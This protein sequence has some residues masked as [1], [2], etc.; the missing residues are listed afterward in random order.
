MENMDAE[1]KYLMHPKME[2]FALHRDIP[3][4]N[5]KK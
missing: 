1:T 4:Q 3:W 2:A 5:K